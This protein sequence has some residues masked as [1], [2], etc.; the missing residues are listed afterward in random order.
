[1]GDHPAGKQTASRPTAAERSILIIAG[2]GLGVFIADFV[3]VA[4]WA[5]NL[6]DRHQDT[7]L[8][9]A[10][11][12][13]VVALLATAWLAV[14]VRIELRRLAQIRRSAPR[15]LTEHTED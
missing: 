7:A 1:M 9:E 10:I 13:W 6:I 12:C 5:P 3:L 14:Q 15:Q 4:I 2:K 11:G 8:A